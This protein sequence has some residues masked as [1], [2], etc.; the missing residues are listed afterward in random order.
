MTYTIEKGIEM[1]ARKGGSG[2]PGKYPF[3]DMEV[4]DSF[5]VPVDDDQDVET[6]KQTVSNCART[7]AKRNSLERTFSVREVGGV[8][9]CWRTK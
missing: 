4:G 2:R 3:S 5:A 8:L 1:P 6:R 9:R 7:W